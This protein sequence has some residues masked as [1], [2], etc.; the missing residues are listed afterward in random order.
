M[1]SLPMEHRF[2]WRT[3]YTTTLSIISITI[4]I[5]NYTY[6]YKPLFLIILMGKR[7]LQLYVDDETIQ[8]ARAKQINMSALFRAILKSEIDVHKEKDPVKKLQLMNAKL[9]SELERVNKKLSKANKQIEDK[10][11]KEEGWQT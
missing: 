9:S 3:T 11:E 1:R 5:T 8:L 7:V 4:Y 10:R 6:I 2:L